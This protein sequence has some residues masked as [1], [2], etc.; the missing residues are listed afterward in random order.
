MFEAIFETLFPAAP[1][2]SA[3]TREK[4][5]REWR[6]IL[7]WTRAG[8]K[9][10]VAF[11]T[12]KRAKDFGLSFDFDVDGSWRDDRDPTISDMRIVVRPRPPRR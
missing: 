5:V 10:E 2:R 4:P 11:P 1:R 3:P 8:E 6:Y 7:S 9:H 12:L